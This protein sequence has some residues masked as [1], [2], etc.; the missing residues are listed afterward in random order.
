MIG[1]VSVSGTWDDMKAFYGSNPRAGASI[2]AAPFVVR[3]DSLVVVIASA[4][5]EKQLT[6]YG[7]QGLQIDAS[8]SGGVLPMVIGHAY[9]PAGNYTAS[10]TS[11]AVGG[12]DAEHMADL[13]G[14]F[15]FGFQR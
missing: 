10:E 8:S 6:L 13:L 1:G 7:V 11:S 2:V 12:Q 5:S 14:V 3:E 4:A 15:V 9:L